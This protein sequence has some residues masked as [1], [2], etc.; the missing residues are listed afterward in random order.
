M[1][2]QFCDVLFVSVRVGG[3]N[4]LD[5]TFLQAGATFLWAAI[6]FNLLLNQLRKFAAAE[7]Y[8]RS[9]KTDSLC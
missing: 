3:D 2:F 1:A 5:F 6:Q 4:F 8:E 9:A 7:R